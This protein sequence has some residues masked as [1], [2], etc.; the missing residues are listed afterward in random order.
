M[1]TPKA[2]DWVEVYYE[3]EWVPF[4]VNDTSKDSDDTYVHGWLFRPGHDGAQWHGSERA[5]DG[6][7]IPSKD[8]FDV[9]GL[10]WRHR[11]AA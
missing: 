3:G 1:T 11:G 4:L 9:G 8:E 2:N 7:G 6:D 5:W 10:H